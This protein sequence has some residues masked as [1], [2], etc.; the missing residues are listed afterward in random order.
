MNTTISRLLL[1]LLLSLLAVPACAEEKPD[2]PR[3]GPAID[4][5]HKDQISFWQPFQ[6][7]LEKHLSRATKDGI[8]LNA[9]DYKGVR[10]DT[11]YGEMTERLEAFSPGDLGD[12]TEKLAFWINAYNFLAIK[13]VADHYPLKSIRDLGSFF[14]PVWKMDAGTI[15]G[16]EY[17]LDEIEHGILRKQ[18]V[19]PRIHFAIVCASL[20]C[21]DIRKDVYLA[22]ELEEQLD[23]QTRTF[24]SN[25]TKGMRLDA[26]SKKALLSMIFSWFGDDFEKSGGVWQFLKRYRPGLGPGKDYAIEYLPYNW[27]LNSI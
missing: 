14:R 11:R 25:P 4:R 1:T 21:P 26:A 10:A 15:G 18:F 12:G 13:I 3:R 22:P 20:S 19:E 8:E 16:R 5:A 24:L 23:G 7:L 27:D 17:S 9:I 6:G 2:E